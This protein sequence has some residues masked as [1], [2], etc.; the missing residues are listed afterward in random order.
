MKTVVEQ[1]GAA[2]NADCASFGWLLLSSR[3]TDQDWCGVYGATGGIW[4]N[5]SSCDSIPHM[6]SSIKCPAHYLIYFCSY[7]HFVVPIDTVNLYWVL[8]W[9]GVDSGFAFCKDFAWFTKK[10]SM[11]FMNSKMVWHVLFQSLICS[12]IFMYF[13][14]AKSSQ[15]KLYEMGFPLQQPCIC[16]VLLHQAA[17]L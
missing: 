9:L 11:Y 10:F 8:L 6:N 3:S 1:R 7:T 5:L 15:R 13:R 2:R 4:W 16:L 14:A 17:I 12:C